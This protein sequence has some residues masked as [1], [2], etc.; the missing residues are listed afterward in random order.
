MP[1]ATA[2]PAVLPTPMAAATAA[3]VALMVP[4]LLASRSTAPTPTVSLPSVL[5]SME[6]L[7][8]DST[9]LVDSAPPPAT[10]MPVLP[11]PSAID[12]AAATARASMVATS[13]ART[14]TLAPPVLTLGTSAMR[15]TISLATEL[16]ASDRPIDTATA[17][18]SVSAAVTAAASACTLTVE[19]SSAVTTSSPL[20]LS[21]S[22]APLMVACT[23]AAMRL[24]V[25]TPAPAIAGL[26]LLDIASAT[27]AAATVA[28]MRLVEVAVTLMPRSAVTLVG[29]VSR[30]MV[31]TTSSGSALPYS[32]QPIILRAIEKPMAT[33]GA[34][35]LKLMPAASEMARTRA[36]MPALLT[37]ETMTRPPLVALAWSALTSLSSMKARAPPP[38]RLTATAPPPATAV[39]S[40]LKVNE[41][42]TEVAVEVA[43]IAADSSA[44]TVTSPARAS[45]SAASAMPACRSVRISLRATLSATEIE[46]LSP[47]GAAVMAIALTSTKAS[48]AAR[49]WPRMAISPPASISLLPSMPARTWV[50]TRLSAI[51]APT[52]TLSVLSVASS[53][54][55]MVVTLFL[56]VAS[57]EA[58]DTALM[59]RSP[60]ARTWASMICARTWAGCRSA[61]PRPNSAS[62]RSNSRFCDS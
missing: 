7:A 22:A 13:L 1:M 55:L 30:A 17:E 8:R 2:M 43:L 26:V 21:I 36:S 41:K 54:V 39:L 12:T 3:M 37:V 15:A 61:M 49:S 58:S 35:P 60:P 6:A 32:C 5:R 50:A 20:P 29:P 46:V 19:M 42:A 56:M 18:L 11:P 34:P 40:P 24:S 14:V 28:S 16:C 45:T 62:A 59:R 31:A 33:A 48:M 38:I 23:L 44:C 27:A 47:L 25:K 53:L 51:T 10:A 57:M 9:T 52:E 4:T